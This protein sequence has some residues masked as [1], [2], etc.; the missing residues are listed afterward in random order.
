MSFPE[1]MIDIETLANTPRSAIVT[2]G[3]CAFNPDTD[4]ISEDTL[5]LCINPTSA[6][7]HGGE[8]MASTVLW[9]IGQPKAA[10]TALTS[11]NALPLPTAMQRLTDWVVGHRENAPGGDLNIWANDPNFDCTILEY[12]YKVCNKTV[13]WAFWEHK[14]CRT[15]AYIGKRLGYDIKRDFPPAGHPPQRPR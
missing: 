5:Y 13:P 11:E 10:Q 4:K 9:W 1:I 14:S 15:I 6:Q 3:A 7:K 8:L 12:A 2:I